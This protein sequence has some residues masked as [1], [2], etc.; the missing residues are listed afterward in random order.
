MLKK[1]WT[2]SLPAT[3]GYAAYL[4]NTYGMAMMYAYSPFLILV[5]FLWRVFNH[6]IANRRASRIVEEIYLMKNGDQILIL[7]VDGIYH[8]VWIQDIASY[9]LIEKKN[10][11]N[12]IIDW[13]HRKYH[14]STD[15]KE[16]I[17]FE[18]I[19]KII[20]GVWIETSITKNDHRTPLNLRNESVVFIDSRNAMNLMNDRNQQKLDNE[21]AKIREQ[22]EMLGIPNYNEKEFY[23]TFK[24]SRIDFINKIK[25]LE[26]SQQQAEVLKLYDSQSLRGRGIILKDIEKRI[27]Q[28]LI[29]RNIKRTS[30]VFGL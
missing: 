24:I 14:I 30:N 10:Y 23:N 25:N 11:M 3:I 27:K 13:S 26:E 16:Y 20:K 4:N 17:N 9:K 2:I 8:K 6:V 22:M 7:T 1:I 12:I 18:I 15:K 21:E 29:N 5:P 28:S 19:D